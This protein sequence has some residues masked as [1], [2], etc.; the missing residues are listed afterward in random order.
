MIVLDASV[1][2]A[3]LYSRD[4]HHVR[5]NGL[6]KANADED[7]TIHPMVMAEV[8]VE[9]ARVGRMRQTLEL[10]DSI[11]I[12][13]WYATPGESVRLAHLRAETGLTLPECCSL[14]VAIEGRASL[15]TFD[16]RLA[17]AAR[18]LGVTVIDTV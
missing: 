5:A 13:Q 10:F 4:M 3:H 6:L 17:D 2:V 9:P 1:L 11:R 7:L 8:L 16:Q 14:A 18:S 12:E 15:A